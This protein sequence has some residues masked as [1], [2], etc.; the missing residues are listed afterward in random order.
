MKMLTLMDYGLT[1]SDNG[2]TSTISRNR[3]VMMMMPTGYDILSR[4]LD[5][6]RRRS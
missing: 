6:N 5:T 1:T 4:N 3:D 2:L